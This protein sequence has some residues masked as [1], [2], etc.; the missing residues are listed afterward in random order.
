M[1]AIE[2][3]KKQHEVLKNLDIT[4]EEFFEKLKEH[5]EFEEKV[6][7]ENKDLLGGDD[8]L[9]PLGMVKEEHKLLLELLERRELERFEEL[10]KY[11][12]TKEETQIF[13]L[14]E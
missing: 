7:R 9:S 13:T 11:H 1:R 4:S 2:K 14:L 5:F 8:E 10:F 3:L 6:L 12:L